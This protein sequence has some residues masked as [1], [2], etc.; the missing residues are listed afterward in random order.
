[1]VYLRQRVVPVHEKFRHRVYLVAIPRVKKGSWRECVHE[2]TYSSGVLLN[3]SSYP[4]LEG[5]GSTHIFI[6]CLRNGLE[7]V[8]ERLVVYE[9]LK[10]S[11]QDREEVDWMWCLPPSFPAL[12]TSFDLTNVS[13]L[14]ISRSAERM[15][16]SSSERYASSSA[17]DM[18]WNVGVDEGTV[19]DRTNAGDRY[20]AYWSSSST[21]LSAVSTH[22]SKLKLTLV[23]E[24]PQPIIGLD[25]RIEAFPDILGR[26]YDVML[27]RIYVRLFHS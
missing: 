5:G 10:M 12:S 27:P 6:V 1:M 13:I 9:S 15:S 22:T 7:T 20:C 14:L 17:G 3:E 2:R 18:S 16:G 23:H 21:S 8:L 11:R 19:P 25:D 4:L 26:A 24:L